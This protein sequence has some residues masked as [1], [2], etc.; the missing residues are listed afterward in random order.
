MEKEPVSY[1]LPVVFVVQLLR[2]VKLV[3]VS[4]TYPAPGAPTWLVR[5]RLPPEKMGC[6]MIG[7]TAVALVSCT[8]SN[9]A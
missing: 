1:R 4:G 2:G 3:V 7:A 9:C 8:S 6:L 5:I